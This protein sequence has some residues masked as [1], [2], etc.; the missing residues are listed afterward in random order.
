MVVPPIFVSPGLILTLGTFSHGTS[1]GYYPFLLRLCRS[2]RI[3]TRN[4]V[5]AMSANGKVDWRVNLGR[6]SGPSRGS[7]QSGQA[8]WDKNGQ[9]TPGSSRLEEAPVVA[10][11]TSPVQ[12][13]EQYLVKLHQSLSTHLSLVIK[14]L[15]DGTVPDDQECT[16]CSR[17]S[18]NQ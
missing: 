18:L 11:L 7:S 14:Q 5:Q 9:I 8:R 10:N 12:F 2:G 15:L 3:N 4:Q 13:S 1:S 17:S 6:V 16:K